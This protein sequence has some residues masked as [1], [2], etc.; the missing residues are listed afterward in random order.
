[1]RKSW[2]RRIAYL[3]IVLLVAAVAAFV[4]WRRHLKSEFQ[5][6]LD[7]LKA[8]GYPVT[9]KELDAWYSIP[10]GAE[11]AAYPILDAAGYYMDL[12]DANRRLM[13]IAGRAELP[14]RT[15]PLVDETMAV[16]SQFLAENAAALDFL[17]EAAEIQHC[18]YPV[19]FTAGFNTLLPHLSDVRNLARLAIL[20]AVFYGERNQPELA[21]PSIKCAFS[22]AGSLE[23]EPLLISQL[24]RLGSQRYAVNG[25]ERVMNRTTLTDRQLF[26]LAC[27]TAGAQS[28]DAMSRA[29]AGE[30]CQG[31][32][33]FQNPRMQYGFFRAISSQTPPKPLLAAYRAAGL[34][35]SDAV[36]YVDMMREYIRLA[37]PPLNQR[38]ERMRAIDQDPR[39][40]N[41]SRFHILA[42]ALMPAL[43]RVGEL[44]L[45]AIAHL[46]TAQAAIAIERYRLAAGVLPVSLADL[47]PEYLEAVPEDPFDGKALRYRKLEPGFVLYSI[48]PDHTDDGGKENPPRSGMCRPNKSGGAATKTRILAN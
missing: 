7:E 24:V 11:N 1:L 26:D 46:R 19:D 41:I 42:R 4:F 14:P 31:V 35:D 33:V 48:G 21:V 13:P 9:C 8:A 23:K 43:A 40:G 15:E 37:E 38:H 32:D 39:Y 5:A 17:Q 34:A 3:L 45:M 27:Q 6:R 30:L 18:R 28:E 29:L 36:I 22:V 2:K 16:I 20:E 12:T 10:A 44:D 47:V 25:L